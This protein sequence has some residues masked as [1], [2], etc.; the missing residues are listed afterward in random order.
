[1]TSRRPFASRLLPA[2][3]TAAGVSL[4]VLLLAA[5]PTDARADEPDTGG[6]DDFNARSIERLALM[7]LR[8]QGAPTGDDYRIAGALFALAQ[9]LAPDDAELAR[10]R[11]E[12]AYRAG[13]Q[14]E[15]MR[16]TRDVVRLDPRDTVAVLR[17]ISMTITRHQ[18]ARERLAAYDR[19][20]G[21]AGT[22]IDPSI[23]SRLALD[24]ALLLRERGD[25]AGFAARLALASRLDATNKDAAA[26]AATYYAQQTSDDPLGEFELIVNL[27]RADPL[28]PQ[29]HLTLARHLARAGAFDQAARFHTIARRL[30]EHNLGGLPE[31]LDIQRLVLDWYRLGEQ[32]PLK[33]LI[34]ELA[35]A[36][37]NTERRIRE[38]RDADQPTSQEP[39]PE[40]IRL[41]SVS[42]QVR[43]L[44]A[45]T[46]GDVETLGAAFSDMAAGLKKVQE[47]LLDPRLL[48][49]GTPIDE[50]RLLVLDLA[51]DQVVF[52]LWTGYQAQ[53]VIEKLQETWLVDPNGAAAHAH[54]DLW[55]ALYDADPAPAL[56]G[57]EALV[58]SYPLALIG[59]G[60]AH[61]RLEDLSGAIV[62]YGSVMRDTPLTPA[63]VWA[64]SRATRLAGRDP[65]RSDLADELARIASEIPPLVD[66][67]SLDPLTFMRLDASLIATDLDATE[68][69]L[70]RIRLQNT[71]S[72][73]LG[74]GSGQPINS[75]LMIAP[76]LDVGITN[77]NQFALPEII[78]MDRRLR[79]MPLEYVEAIISVDAGFT[80]W[81]AQTAAT[82]SQR[83]R[84]RIIQGFRLSNGTT[85]VGPLCLTKDIPQSRRRPNTFTNLTTPELADHL[86][87]SGSE[88]FPELLLAIRSWAMSDDAP[89]DLD[90]ENLVTALIDRY[91]GASAGERLLMLTALPHAGVAPTMALFDEAVALLALREQ[92]TGVLLVLMVTRAT[93]LDD[94]IFAAPALEQNEALLT[95]AVAI[96]ERLAAGA[97]T[98]ATAGPSIDSFAGISPSLDDQP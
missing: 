42:E 34:D 24:A 28:D 1:M 55:M 53:G 81:Y 78:E 37:Y 23:R 35:Q 98:Y 41:S 82:T 88:Q 86:T 21:P 9:T 16:A 43:I 65:A 54:L 50:I 11:A 15:L 31:S 51:I 19:Y 58:G 70:V 63:A 74:L 47:I 92:D 25:D 72:A 66:A 61:E 59:V 48:P 67:M 96:R 6:T 64:R 4:A 7:D 8:L 60:L 94:P 93:T 52:H 27:L 69:L 83:M 68:P 38:L 2:I 89:D 79:L 57:F 95:T 40:D 18:T 26:L 32:I 87:E 36:R 56:A 45:H 17:L 73:P 62:S 39:K 12:A 76:T 33:E 71:S 29:V 5:G 49:P 13:D 10:R 75:R 77:R 44:A 80:G 3:R 22:S 90:G 46:A 84:A 91:S 14:D 20:L 97:T 85:I 30:T